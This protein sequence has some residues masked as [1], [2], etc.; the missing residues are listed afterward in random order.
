M[1]NTTTNHARRGPQS[2]SCSRSKTKEMLVR[3]DFTLSVDQAKLAE[4]KRELQTCSAAPGSR[5]RMACA[6]LLLQH[7]MAAANAVRPSLSVRVR[8]IEGCASRRLVIDWWSFTTAMCNAVR[9]SKSWS[10]WLHLNEVKHQ[11]NHN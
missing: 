3:L 5:C 9:K 2:T 8:L 1:R 10:K 4:T 11:Q 6:H 7:I